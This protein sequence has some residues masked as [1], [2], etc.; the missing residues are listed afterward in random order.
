MHLQLDIQSIHLPISW[1]SMDHYSSRSTCNVDFPPFYQSSY[2]HNSLNRS[3]LWN[4]AN[5]GY[6]EVVCYIP[7]L[8][9]IFLWFSSRIVWLIHI[10]W[11]N[12]VII[13]WSPILSKWDWSLISEINILFDYQLEM[14]PFI[15][16]L[17]LLLLWI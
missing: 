10:L 14:T 17:S 8:F 1:V 13:H 16:I 4:I 9:H 2:Q 7:L 3:I 5:H 12:R 15:S 11:S 6:F